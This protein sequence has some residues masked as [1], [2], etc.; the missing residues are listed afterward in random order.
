MKFCNLGKEHMLSGISP[1]SLLRATFNCS[2]LLMSPIVSGNSPT[3]SLPLTS[4]TVTF[5]SAPMSGGKHPVS[6]EFVMMIWLRVFD[7]FDMLEGRQ[8]LRLL[9]AMTITETGEL[10]MFGGRLKLKLLLL[11]NKASSFKSNTLAGTLPWY[12]LKRMS[13]NLREGR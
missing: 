7:M 4:K 3:R 9:F 6:P 11:M 8:L 13:R 5:F 1:D 2:K 12:M 10:P